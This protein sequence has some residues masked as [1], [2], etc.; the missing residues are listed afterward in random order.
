MQM[1]YISTRGGMEPI[2][3]KEVVITGLAPDGGLI[4][5][6]RIPDF[7]SMLDDW[8]D[9]SYE[10]L[11]FGILRP[12]VDIPAPKLREL[13]ERSYARFDSPDVAP[14]VARDDLY[15][16]ELF[17]GPTL[18]FKDIALQLLGNLFDHIL[19]ERRAR[20]NILAATS[21]DTGSAAIEGV[22][23]RGRVSIFVMHPKGRI[24]PLQERQMTTVLDEN[25]FN[26]AVEGSFDDCQEIM[27]SIFCDT[28]FKLEHSLGSV[29]SVNWARVLAQIVYYFHAFLQLRRRGVEAPLQFAVPTGNFGDILAG[30]Y[31]ARMGLP[32]ARLILATNE[33]N[34]LARF[35]NSGE[36]RRGD[37]ARTISPAMD[38]QVASNFER[39]LYYRLDCDAARVRALMNDFRNTGG[40]SVPAL[41]SRADEGIFAAGTADTAET[42]ETIRRMDSECGYVPDPHTAVGIAV[43]R[44][45]RDPELPLVCLATAHPAKFSPA[46]EDALGRSVRHPILDHLADLPARQDDLPAEREAVE[47]Y[48]AKALGQK[49]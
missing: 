41:R 7:S 46:I 35:F 24:A 15:M 4:I 13:I 33:N 22:R 3:F 48:I 17:H 2:G 32:I 29:N 1:N 44:R 14:L 19:D 36:Y 23:G 8:R 20:L 43:G 30:Y 45:L 39:Y 27:K 11:A 18:A 40:I 25:V 16:L 9:L 26:L 34:I 38:I 21:G 12:Y 10:D 5:P 47:D 49:T 37:V 28:E 42:L 6:E 31:A